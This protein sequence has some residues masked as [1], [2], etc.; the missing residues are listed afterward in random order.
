MALGAMLLITIANA[1]AQNKWVWSSNG[2]SISSG[3]ASTYYPGEVARPLYRYLLL[4]TQQLRRAQRQVVGWKGKPKWGGR[5]STLRCF[6]LSHLS[7]RSEE[8]LEKAICRPADRIGSRI[9]SHITA[10]SVN[11]IDTLSF[12]MILMM[13]TFAYSLL[14]IRCHNTD[15]DFLLFSHF[16]Y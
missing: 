1:E 5:G 6:I 12:L 16:R 15:E 13:L 11:L 3:G 9:S 10:E 2:R 8:C 4:V 7:V 14:N